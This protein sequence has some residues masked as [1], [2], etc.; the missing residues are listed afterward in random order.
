MTQ[1]GSDALSKE[2]V[3]DHLWSPKNDAILRGEDV[4]LEKRTVREKVLTNV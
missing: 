2:V 4:Y 3:T 1:T